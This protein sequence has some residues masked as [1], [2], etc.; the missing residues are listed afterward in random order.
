M[1]SKGKRHL[2]NVFLTDQQW[3]NF[4]IRAIKA[5]KTRGDYMAHLIASQD[6]ND[7]RM[8]KMRERIQELGGVPWL[9]PQKETL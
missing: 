5:G 8:Q 4:Q 6:W 9:D 2:L 7:F 1:D 3:Q